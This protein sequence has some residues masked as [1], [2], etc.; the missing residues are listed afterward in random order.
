MNI[1]TTN[2]ADSA[3]TP[4][5]RILDCIPTNRA[6]RLGR[7]DGRYGLSG[8]IIRIRRGRREFLRTIRRAVS[9]V[10]GKRRGARGWR[11]G[12]R[13]G[14]TDSRMSVSRFLRYINNCRTFA[15]VF[16]CFCFVED[17]LNFDGELPAAIV[18]S[19]E[20]KIEEKNQ[21][22]RSAT[23]PSILLGSIRWAGRKSHLISALPPRPHSDAGGS[24][25]RVLYNCPF[26]NRRDAI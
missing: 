2:I 1:S 3:P 11:G 8:E 26:P 5:A 10:D 7:I 13:G 12:W 17:A 23:S 16:F 19:K 22:F 6:E 25:H 21:R 4:H 15:L 24:L 14:L 18:E 9:M 20:H